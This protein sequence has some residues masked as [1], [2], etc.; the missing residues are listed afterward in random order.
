MA[1][2]AWL[3]RGSWVCWPRG[4]TWPALRL[5]LASLRGPTWLALRLDLAGLGGLAWP[6]LK[7]DLEAQ[8]GQPLSLVVLASWAQW[9]K[10]RGLVVLLVRF[11]QADR[12]SSFGGFVF[13]DLAY[14]R[15]VLLGEGRVCL[16]PL[17]IRP[18]AHRVY[19]YLYSDRPSTP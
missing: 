15:L 12:E 10:P 4:S 16:G 5:D 1:E 11:Y 3:R 8:L 14:S 18:Q 13:S 7:L 6:V 19:Q 9:S 17:G 2:G